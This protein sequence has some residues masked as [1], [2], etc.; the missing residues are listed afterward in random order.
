MATPPGSRP[1]G[2]G[3]FLVWASAIGPN[4]IGAIGDFSLHV[5]NGACV[6]NAHLAAFFSNAQHGLQTVRFDADAVPVDIPVGECK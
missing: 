5:V 3:G 2:K 1:G 6:V 4:A